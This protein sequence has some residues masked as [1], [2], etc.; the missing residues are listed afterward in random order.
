[1]Y[2]LFLPRVNGKEKVTGGEVAE[3][4]VAR[5]PRCLEGEA[6]VYSFE[7]EADEEDVPCSRELL[8]T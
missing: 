7:E 6:K 5:A 8:F 2:D 3:V 1:M 4:G